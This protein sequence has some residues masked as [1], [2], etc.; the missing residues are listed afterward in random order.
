MGQ[1]LVLKKPN[2]D[3]LY[4]SLN[5]LLHRYERDMLNTKE[6]RW[7]NSFSALRPWYLHNQV[8]LSLL[9]SGND[10]MLCNPYKWNYYL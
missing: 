3:L 2:L 1:P 8:T 10:P 9:W 7:E 5:R 6:P 4:Y